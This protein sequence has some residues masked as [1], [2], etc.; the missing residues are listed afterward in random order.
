[1]GE[2][3][4]TPFA[5]FGQRLKMIREAAKE[6]VDEV[7]GAVEIAKD[8]LLRIENGETRPAEDVLSLLASHFDLADIEED[9]LWELAGYSKTESNDQLQNIASIMLMPF[10]GRIVYSDMAQVTVNNFGV[11]MNFMQVAGPGKQPMAIARIGMSR[12]H[13]QSVLEL[14]QKTLD[15]SKP[16][17]LKQPEQDDKT[18]DS[19]K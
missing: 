4:K 7:S 3:S 10:D 5:S 1:M 19:K 11:V 12:E 15:S 2:N 14:L 6:S 13:A 8:E 16:K 18:T 17:M 9:K